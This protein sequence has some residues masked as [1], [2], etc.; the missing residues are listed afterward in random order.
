[1]YY[2]WWIS[3]FAMWGFWLINLL[4]YIF[5]ILWI[6][7]FIINFVNWNINKIEWWKWND[8]LDILNKRYAKWEIDKK[9]YEEKRKDIL[10]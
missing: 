6:I 5:I 3:S 7:Y 4:L 8:A 9:E 1:M 10:K 2:W